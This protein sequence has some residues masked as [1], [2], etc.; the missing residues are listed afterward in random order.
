[1]AKIYVAETMGKQVYVQFSG[2][3]LRQIHILSIACDFDCDA[4]NL[5]RTSIDNNTLS[6]TRLRGH[7]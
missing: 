1:M 6:Q 2:Y 4:M 5:L 3:V 7:D